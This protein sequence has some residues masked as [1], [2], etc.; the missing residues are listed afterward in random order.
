MGRDLRILS[1]IE[2]SL[3]AAEVRTVKELAAAIALS[4]S[5]FSRL[6]VLQTGILP[7][8][9]LRLIRRFQDEAQRARRILN[10]I[11]MVH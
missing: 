8:R 4:P 7:G 1:A 5:R 2:L 11:G 10:R 9:H 3:S 6:F